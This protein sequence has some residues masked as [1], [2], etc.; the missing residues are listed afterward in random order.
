MIFLPVI[1]SL[2][3]GLC[4]QVILVPL[5]AEDCQHGVSNALK[6]IAKVLKTLF[7]VS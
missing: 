7:I 5:Q 1:R 3:C 4:E 2:L 6:S